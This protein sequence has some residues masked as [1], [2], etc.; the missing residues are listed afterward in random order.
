MERK[1][2]TSVKWLSWV[3]KAARQTKTKSRRF[4]YKEFDGPRIGG[5]VRRRVEESTSRRVEYLVH[6]GS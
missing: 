5:E 6:A 2:R 4:I 1:D 3:V